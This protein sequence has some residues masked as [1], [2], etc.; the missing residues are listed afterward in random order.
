MMC[1]K[2]PQNLYGIIQQKFPQLHFYDQLGRRLI[3]CGWARDSSFGM[4]LFY[5]SITLLLGPADMVFFLFV[6]EAQENKFC[7][8]EL[9]KLLVTIY[10]LIYYWPKPITAPKL[11]SKNREMNST[12]RGRMRRVNNVNNIW[13]IEKKESP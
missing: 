12:Y 4:P 1:S 13:A 9:F 6:T 7:H 5:V 11:R 3:E 10:L 2:Q 8:V